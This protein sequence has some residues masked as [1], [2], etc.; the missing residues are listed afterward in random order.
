MNQNDHEHAEAERLLPAPARPQ[1]SADR[2]QLLR[3]HLMSEINRER[4]AAAAARPVRSR[5]G[6]IA[7]PALVGGLALTLVLT[8][9][10]GE[11]PGA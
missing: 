6:R 9:N 5:I 11:E 7:L 10:G 4:T 1:L 8:A 2:H 3:G